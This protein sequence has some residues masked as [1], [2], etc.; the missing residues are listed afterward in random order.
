VDGRTDRSATGGNNKGAEEESM[1]YLDGWRSREGEGEWNVNG[2]GAGSG[3]QQLGF[4]REREREDRS[5]SDRLTATGCLGEEEAKKHPE[6]P[7]PGPTAYAFLQ[8]PAS[9]KA[10]KIKKK[11]SKL[12]Q[13]FFKT[14]DC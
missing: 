14:W 2:E 3:W 12:K 4:K 1:I 13:H 8:D 7:N 10:Q 11:Q 6:G 5:A 9:Y